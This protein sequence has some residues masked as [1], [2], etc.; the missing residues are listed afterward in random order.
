MNLPII[1]QAHPS[2]L[3]C[4]RQ[5]IRAAKTLLQSRHIDQW[6]DGYPDVTVLQDDIARGKGYVL[7]TDHTIHGYFALSFEDELP[8]QHIENGSWLIEGPY[9][10]LHRLALT[11][12]LRGTGAADRIIEFWEQQTIAQLVY[13]LRAD[14]H[15]QNLPVRHLL[16]QHGFK[17]CGIIYVRA[18][19][20][21][22]AFEKVLS[23]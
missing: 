21:R 10:V 13:S 7:E 4:I 17:D 18:G 12:T 20:A 2:D 15:P 6:Q 14:T 1:R 5:I 9:S 19:Q 11:E 22:H 8:Y 23:K 3:S 16:Q